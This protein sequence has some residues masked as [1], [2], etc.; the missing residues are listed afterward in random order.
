VLVVSCK[1]LSYLSFFGVC[2][3]V[4]SEVS[5]FQIPSQ[6]LT[7]KPVVPMRRS[8]A[9]LFTLTLWSSLVV[10]AK[11]ASP[12][13]EAFWMA[14]FELMEE[15]IKERLEKMDC[16][17]SPEYDTSVKG[18]MMG[19][20]VRN[21]PNSERILGRSVLYFPIFERH[22]R[23]QN[24]PLGLKYLPVLESALNPKAI[25]RVGAG[26][27]WQFMP[28]TGAVYGLVIDHTRDDRADPEKSTAAAMKHLRYLYNRFENWELA[29]AAYNAGGGRV[30]RAIKRSRSRNFW[31]V[32]RYLPRETRNY[33]PGFIAATYLLQYYHHHDLKPLYPSLDL[34]LTESV[35]INDYLSFY[36]IAQVTGLPL[37][38]IEALNPAFTRGYI[39]AT[40][41]GSTLRLPKRVMPAILDFLEI[42]RQ[43]NQQVPPSLFNAPVTVRE[44]DKEVANQKSYYKS[45]YMVSQGDNLYYL[46]DL[47]N[48]TEH[49]ILAWNGLTSPDLT[50]G[51]E[52]I[53]YQP[54]QIKRY[55]NVE[56]QT[57]NLL[58]TKRFQ[59]DV[60]QPNLSLQPDPDRIQKR[61]H[62]T[63]YRIAGHE[64][65][66]DLLG[67][68]PGL[69]LE[70]L[71]SWNK[72]DW[73]EQ[74]AAGDKLKVRRH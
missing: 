1:G 33:V 25:S 67:F 30:N 55:P 43:K 34:Q 3:Q 70:Q 74:P 72:L 45:V 56:V 20:L 14:E 21:R 26:G 54:R 18:Y 65:L 4:R 28:T 62:Y 31:R 36:R 7:I 60:A 41:N 39:P 46:A 57:L 22:L 19:Y 51:Q 64:T 63:Y 23:E 66:F 40:S 29:L 17:V 32:R 37:E 35:T 16:V 52:L 71:Q 53:I 8:F 5:Q 24:M 59:V 44:K 9:L 2:L 13:E 50:P 6:R 38:T 11:A 73:N 15:E 47:F 58:S 10:S 48:C 69:T 42:V 49:A 68:F 12:E 61:R 27:L